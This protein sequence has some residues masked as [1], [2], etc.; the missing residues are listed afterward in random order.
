MIFWV[1]LLIMFLVE[2]SNPTVALSSSVPKMSRKIQENIFDNGSSQD[3]T[4]SSSSGTPGVVVFLVFAA[5]LIVVVFSG[6]FWFFRRQQDKE[7]ERVSRITDIN[8]NRVDLK[9]KSTCS[10]E[11]LSC[12]SG[13]DESYDVELAGHLVDGIND[14]MDFSFR[15]KATS[16]PDHHGSQACRRFSYLLES[17]DSFVGIDC[18]DETEAEPFSTDK[19]MCSGPICVDEEVEGV[20][21]EVTT[22]SYDSASVVTHRSITDSPIADP[23][24]IFKDDEDQLYPSMMPPLPFSYGNDIFNISSLDEKPD[25][26][27]KISIQ[28]S[29]HTLFAL[30]NFSSPLPQADVESSA[31][32]ASVT[33]IPKRQRPRKRRRSGASQERFPDDVSESSIMEEQAWMEFQQPTQDESMKSI[34]DV[35]AEW[36]SILYRPQLLPVPLNLNNP[37]SSLRPQLFWLPKITPVATPTTKVEI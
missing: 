32:E 17:L 14:C 36:N 21:C 37:S 33:K 18:D 20:E 19:A 25:D 3:L 1:P 31:L 9:D 24:L 7:L 29:A 35:M 2:K 34:Q 23:I 28:A 16:G 5:L 4:N 27:Q 22:D 8:E 30:L 13:V 26:V 6:M 15:T 10:D 11:T 12:S